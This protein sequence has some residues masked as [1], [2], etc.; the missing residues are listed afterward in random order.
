M[1]CF[2]FKTYIEMRMPRC[3][4][5]NCGQFT[6]NPE[7]ARPR[8]GF[9][10]LF[11]ALVLALAK[12]MPVSKIGAMMQEAGSR[13]WAIIHKISRQPTKNKTCLMPQG[14]A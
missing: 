6:Y 10:L 2:Q 13:L 14:L 5:P 11:E 1:S 12:E 7:W 4:C 8:S 3:K 9:S